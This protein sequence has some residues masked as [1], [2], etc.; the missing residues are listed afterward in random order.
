ME[1]L[2]NDPQYVNSNSDGVNQQG[3]LANI[4]LPQSSDFFVV[5]VD[6][7]FGAKWKFMSSYRYYRFRQFA[8]TQVDI[9][10]V[11]PGDQFG[12]PASSAPRPQK[13][14]YM[15][16]GLTTTITPNLTNDFHFSYLR[17][18]WQWSTVGGPP[19]LPGLGGAVEMGGE[20]AGV[21]ALIPYNVNSQSF[22]NRFWDGQDKLFRDYLYLLHGNPPHHF[23]V[24]YPP[25][26]HYHHPTTT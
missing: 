8:S 21:D 25:N 15:V 24:H 22:R 20:T 12:V 9:G 13:P 26:P 2:P 1:P 23:S 5:R 7:D 17:N 3:Y 6:H 11:L 14:S 16:A 4:R 19:Q 10:G 18:F